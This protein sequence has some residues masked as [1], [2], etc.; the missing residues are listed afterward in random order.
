M[1]VRLWN[2][3]AKSSQM[4]F[5]SGEDRGCSLASAHGD[6]GTGGVVPRGLDN[7][8]TDAQRTGEGARKKSGVLDVFSL[9]Q[10]RQTGL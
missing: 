4:S 8:L 7:E 3:L 9:E 5:I 6:A 2:R 10:L 1:R